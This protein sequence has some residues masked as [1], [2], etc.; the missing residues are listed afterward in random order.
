[1]IHVI[2]TAAQTPELLTVSMKIDP[3]SLLPK[4]FLISK[5]SQHCPNLLD[6]ITNI[7][8]STASRFLPTILS[9]FP[10]VSVDRCLSNS[11]LHVLFWSFSSIL[12]NIY[13][14]PSQ[15]ACATIDDGSPISDI[16]ELG[17][18]NVEDQWHTTTY[19]ALT[20]DRSLLSHP[21]LHT[22]EG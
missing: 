16:E 14:S 7:P 22:K 5:V 8:A 21:K 11:F 17:P 6:A 1:M 9:T 12:S 13:E 10:F 3:P 15:L 2:F 20:L 4:P 19:N 18:F